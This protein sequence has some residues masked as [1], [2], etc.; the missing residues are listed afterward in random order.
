[1]CLLTLINLGYRGQLL[2]PSGV[3]HLLGTTAQGPSFF[4]GVFLA[5][6]RV[7]GR[8][9]SVTPAPWYMDGWVGASAR[10]SGTRIY[11]TPRAR[12]SLHSP[13][14]RSPT[15]GGFGAAHLGCHGGHADRVYPPYASAFVSQHPCMHGS[16]DT[17]QRCTLAGTLCWPL[18]TLCAVL[19]APASLLPVFPFRNDGLEAFHQ[20]VEHCANI[21]N[22]DI[23][24]AT[25]YPWWL[26]KGQGPKPSL[27][28]HQN[29]ER[30]AVQLVEG[31]AWQL[32]IVN[33]TTMAFMRSWTDTE[34]DHLAHGVYT[35]L[36][37]ATQQTREV[38]LRHA[39]HD[40]HLNS[41]SQTV[42][43][44]QQ[45]ERTSVVPCPPFYG[46]SEVLLLENLVEV[47]LNGTV[48]WSVPVET[49]VCQRPLVAAGKPTRSSQG[50]EPF[51]MNA[52]R[53]LH[54]E[55]AV[56][57]TSC[58]Q[59]TAYKVH[60]PTGRLLWSVGLQGSINC[61]LGDGLAYGSPFVSPLHHFQPSSPTRFV[62]FANFHPTRGTHHSFVTEVEVDAANRTCRVVS[63]LMGPPR[64]MGGAVIIGADGLRGGVYGHVAETMRIWKHGGRAQVCQFRAS[65]MYGALV[66]YPD[67]GMHVNRTHISAHAV[68]YETEPIAAVVAIY[69]LAGYLLHYL[70][71]VF[72]PPYLQRWVHARALNYSAV[73]VCISTPS[74]QFR[75]CRYA[76]LA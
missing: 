16:S 10:T 20:R 15:N 1:M 72:M 49:F 4:A 14:V 67:W 61:T 44:V 13:L 25:Q 27:L 41:R 26:N 52:V 30:L 74:D 54:H 63:E 73:H 11:P 45:Y 51:H 28:V 55:Q 66:L 56:L 18:L 47:D 32:Q 48:L 64:A 43:Y 70:S 35:F 17:A 37:V 42:F 12:V 23:A 33:S 69:S 50:K 36:N 60:Y 38:S 24:F 29:P 58:Y 22:L 75:A 57:A 2:I 68:Y 62:A 31:R 7:G 40:A 34:D 46:T 53:F 59:G 9:S 19:V 65:F 39:T 8:P 71:E 6:G 21:F 76:T 5:I 3:A